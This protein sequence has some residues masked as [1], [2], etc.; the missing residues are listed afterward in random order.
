MNQAMMAASAAPRSVFSDPTEDEKFYFDMIDRRFPEGENKII[1][2]GKPGHAVYLIHKFLSE[3]KK[4][5]QLCTGRLSREF[6]GVNAYGDPEIAKAAIRFLQQEGSELSIVV[7]DQS[8]LD[9]LDGQP[10]E[11]HPLV[12]QLRKAEDSIR[13]NWRV[14][15]L[16]TM[17]DRFPFHFVVIDKKSFRVEVNPEKAEAYVNFGDEEFGRSFV[18]LFETMESVS[19]PLI[20][21]ELNPN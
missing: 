8:G 16:P 7:V 13:G 20:S 6:D 1:S 5:I 12:E 14:S 18:G 10:P 21:G 2:N 9:L 11:S 15:Q 19:D 4:N 3:A 17:E